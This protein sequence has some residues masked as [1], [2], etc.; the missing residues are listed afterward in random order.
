M[1]VD[2]TVSRHEIVIVKTIVKPMDRLQ[3]IVT[4]VLRNQPRVA[5]GPPEGRPRARP[6]V[7]RA[8]GQQHRQD[9][10]D[11]VHVV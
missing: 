1:G 2:S 8:G 10:E 7:L 5:A 11:H 4:G 9:G 6:G 3:L